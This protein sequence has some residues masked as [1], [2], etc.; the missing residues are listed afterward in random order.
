MSTAFYQELFRP[1]VYK[2]SQGRTTRMATGA[3]IGV[4]AVLSCWR[5]MGVFGASHWMLHYLL[6]GL[7]LILGL[8][9]AFR[10]V[11]WPR[12]ADFLIAVEGEVVK[13]KWPSRLELIRSSVVVLVTL[14]LLT[15][16]LFVY[17]LFWSFLLIDWMQIAGAPQ[18]S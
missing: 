1:A 3:A 8:W 9:V 12:F 4:V 7:L 2:R 15:S 16:F 6:P 14:A 11:N 13:V 5:L 17:D 10:I 18:A